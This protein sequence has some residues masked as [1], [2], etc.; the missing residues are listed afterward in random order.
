MLKEGPTALFIN[1]AVV[2]GR[3]GVLPGQRTVDKTG[4]GLADPVGFAVVGFDFAGSGYHADCSYRNYGC[5]PGRT[6]K[7]R[8]LG[9][10]SLPDIAA[11][12]ME[13][14]WLDSVDGFGSH[15]CLH[16]LHTRG[17]S[18]FADTG[19]AGYGSIEPGSIHGTEHGRIQGFVPPVSTVVDIFQD[20]V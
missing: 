16:T 11:G 3:I 15:S 10:G 4:F 14:D 19:F 13:P 17:C 7:C 5:I 20:C 12:N 8:I 6:E 9:S 1:A 18:G 2:V